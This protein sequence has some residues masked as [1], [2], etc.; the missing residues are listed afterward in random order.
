MNNKKWNK[1]KYKKYIDYLKNLEDKEYKN[2]NSKLVPNIDS[3]N[4]IGIRIPILRKIAKKIAKNEY[5][6]FL[7]LVQNKYFE[8]TL[9]EGLIISNIDDLDT[10]KKY[11]EKYIKK[12][13]NWA[14]CDTF[15][16][17]LKIVEKNKEKLFEYFK[18]FLTIDSE[19]IIRCSLIVFLNFYNDEKYLNDIFNSVNNINSEY[20]YVKMAVA[21]LLSMI[22]VKYPDKTLIFLKNNNLDTFT[23]N[24]TIQKI[25]ESKKVN[26]EEKE[27]LRKLKR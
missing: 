22:Y 11:Y 26:N 1:E 3:K 15:C 18:D 10:F 6:S 23:H 7:E 13:D 8:E 17:S 21:W 27:D 20:Y 4:M 19:Y 14:T 24:K 12:I 2:F 9:I 25:I 16:N 5:Y